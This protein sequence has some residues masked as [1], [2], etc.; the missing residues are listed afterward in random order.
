[1]EFEFDKEMDALLR[2]AAKGGQATAA[3][4]ESHLDADEISMFAENAMPDTSKPRVIKH[5]A[6][7]NR[8]RTTLSNVVILNREAGIEPIV[9][10]VTEPEVDSRPAVSWISTLLSTKALAFGFGAIALLFIGFLGIGLFSNLNSGETQ[11][12]KAED[13]KVAAP[14]AES[15]ADLKSSNTNVSANSDANADLLEG[16]TNSDTGGEIATDGVLAPNSNVISGKDTAIRNQPADADEFTGSRK[17]LGR[18][19][20][21]ED[22][23]V[24][25]S[26]EETLA[27]MEDRSASPPPPARLPEATTAEPSASVLTTRG[28]TVS[29]SKKESPATEAQEKKSND[30]GAGRSVSN[31]RQINGRNFTRRNGV[32]YDEAYKNQPTIK[33]RRGTPTFSALDSGVRDIA[34]HLDG[35]VIV[36]WKSKAYRIQ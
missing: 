29:K 36:L 31:A 19:R 27:D 26:R 23:P 24:G 18:L 33:I 3:A 32:W 20:A 12:A 28:A 10:S 30:D 13:T 8:C 6:D 2:K 14:I 17:D 7:C 22:K 1:M 16:D 15:E 25:A 34:N 35:T 5:L 4:L 11:M 9:E 21:N